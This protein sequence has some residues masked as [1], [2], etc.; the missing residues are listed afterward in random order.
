[1]PYCFSPT[2]SGYDNIDQNLILG[3]RDLF[4]QPSSA[5]FH[6]GTHCDNSSGIS[7]REHLPSDW[8]NGPKPDWINDTDEI[9]GLYGVVRIGSDEADGLYYYFW[10][11]WVDLTG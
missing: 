2:P 7:L 8:Q 9:N 1:M 10:I 3:S 6:L 5:R 4:I 11:G